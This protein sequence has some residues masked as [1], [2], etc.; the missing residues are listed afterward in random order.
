VVGAVALEEPRAGD[1]L[2]QVA[3]WAART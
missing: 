1:V 3:A 2:G